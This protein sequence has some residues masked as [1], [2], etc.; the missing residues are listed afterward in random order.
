MHAVGN[1]CLRMSDHP[2][3]DLQ[4]H[5]HRIERNTDKGAFARNVMFFCGLGGESGGA[6]ER[7]RFSMCGFYRAH[8][9]TIA[10]SLKILF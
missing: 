8:I 7:M 10:K 3:D 4:R 5:Q 1:Q 9:S 2:D 6:C